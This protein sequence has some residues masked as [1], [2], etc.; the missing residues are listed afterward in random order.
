[1]HVSSIWSFIPIDALRM[2]LCASAILDFLVY[3][4]NAGIA[5]AETI[6]HVHAALALWERRIIERR[7]TA[8][9]VSLL[10]VDH[11]TLAGLL[12]E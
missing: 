6:P 10:V 8:P 2:M 11:L 5:I 7:A 3:L 9:D 12:N 4:T 1:M